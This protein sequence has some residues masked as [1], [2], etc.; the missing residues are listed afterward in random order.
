MPKTEMRL[1]EGAARILLEDVRWNGEPQCPKCSTPDP[2][3]VSTRNIYKCRECYHF[4]SVTSGTPF[5]SRKLSLAQIVEAMLLFEE[6]EGKIRA[7][8]LARKLGVEYK[9]ALVMKRKITE[10]LLFSGGQLSEPSYISRW[11]WQGF[12]FWRLNEQGQVVRENR[13]TG[14]VRLAME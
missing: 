14:E 5:A 7:A 11:Y 8:E 6:S 13:K 2:Y 4:F 3:V 1:T 9:V 12:N 10:S